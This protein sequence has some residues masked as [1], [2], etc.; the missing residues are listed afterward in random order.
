MQTVLKKNT[1]NAFSLL[2]K[3]LKLKSP[4]SREYNLQELTGVGSSGDHSEVLKQGKIIHIENDYSDI[5]FDKE[6]L[7]ELKELFIKTRGIII[8]N[9][10][11][12]L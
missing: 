7:L 10:K 11:N 3:E 12:S 9:C 1:N 8:S 4:L 6:I 2:E 5:Q